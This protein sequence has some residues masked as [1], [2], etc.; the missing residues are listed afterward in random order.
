M[1]PSCSSWA[2]LMWVVMGIHGSTL[3]HH[4][5]M[6]A[7]D[8]LGGETYTSVWV[9][10]NHRMVSVRRNLWISS[11][12]R[13]AWGNYQNWVQLR[14]NPGTRFLEDPSW[15]VVVSP[16]KDAIKWRRTQWN[17]GCLW[18]FSTQSFPQSRFSLFSG[19][20]HRLRWRIW[21]ESMGSLCGVQ[22]QNLWT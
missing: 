10:E 7:Q 5:L 1:T 18:P 12:P 2:F 9:K 11:S 19:K 16:Q 13:Q 14:V 15:Q 21:E 4:G 17:F 20:C 3:C 8:Y 22:W 6:H